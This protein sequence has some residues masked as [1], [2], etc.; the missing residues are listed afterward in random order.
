[1]SGNTNT[2]VARVLK[3]IE[4]YGRGA[5]DSPAHEKDR[6]N[7]TEVMSRMYPEL[8][9]AGQSADRLPA[10]AATVGRLDAKIRPRSFLSRPIQM[11]IPARHRGDNISRDQPHRI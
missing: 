8:S 1:M 3:F 10:L 9:R 5:G 2:P 11:S 7:L 4:R 6:T